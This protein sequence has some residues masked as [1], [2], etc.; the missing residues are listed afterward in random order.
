MNLAYFDCYNGISGDMTL[1]AL[2]DLGLD[3]TDLK[4]GLASLPVEGF[5]I[6]AVAV[7]RQGIRAT[8]VDVSVDESKDTHRTLGDLYKILDGSQLPERVRARAREAFRRL[9]E[10]EAEVHRRPVERIHF[11][12]VGCIDA[13]VDIAG[14]MLAIELLGIERVVASP[15]ATGHGMVRCRHGELP[16]PAPA[17]V[18]ILRGVPIYSGGIE[19]ELTTPTGAAIIT[20]LAESF[21]PLPPMIPRKI[22]YG[23]GQRELPNQT[24]CLRVIL[25]EPAEASLPSAHSMPSAPSPELSAHTQSEILHV[26][27]TE[28]DDMNPEFF[29]ALIERL[30]AA[31][32][33]DVHWIPVQM[34]KNR[35]GVSLHVLADAAHRDTLAAMVLR[36]TST[37]GLR[38]ATVERHCLRRS[39]GSIDTPFGPIRVKIGYWGE[40]IL[41]VTPE[42]EEC[43]RQAAAHDVPLSR[44]YQA[45]VAEIERRYFAPT[46]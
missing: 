41:K 34:K 17:T 11:H 25:G 32:A 3:V 4:K 16:V 13:I 18:Q 29:S 26:I 24:N 27:E 5:D 6:Q 22:A 19:A 21:G 14:A 23:A 7:K 44:V 8:R 30:F 36:E 45:A 2:V 42:Y 10:A 9:A 15:I 1:G 43:R 28:I 39:F 40:T 20:T 33:H 37:F 46:G 31:G 38:I 12:E 35:P